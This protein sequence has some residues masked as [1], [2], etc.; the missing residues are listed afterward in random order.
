M[1]AV[2]YASIPVFLV[3]VVAKRKDVPFS[4]VVVLFGA[5]ILAC[6]STHVVHVIGIWRPVDWWQALVDG[7]CALISLASAVVIWPLLP[8]ILAIPSPAQ[9]RALNRELER[10]KGTLVHTQGEL[11]RAYEEVEQRVAE[12]TAELARANQALQVEIGERRRAEETLRETNEYLDNLFNCASAPII[13]WDTRFRI[14]RFNHAF[15][16]LTGRGA[17]EVLGHSLEI[18]FPLAQVETSM[19]SFRRQ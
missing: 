15:E 19:G 11:R 3:V 8:R 6:G 12:R 10:E 18:L 2:S 14:T 16:A 5:F 9:L 1:I 7:L 17:V 4:W 13:V